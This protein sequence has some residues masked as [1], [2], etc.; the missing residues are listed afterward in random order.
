MLAAGDGSGGGRGEDDDEPTHLNGG[1]GSGN[2]VKGDGSQVD[3]RPAHLQL[4]DH[5]DMGDSSYQINNKDVGHEGDCNGQ[6]DDGDAGHV[7][8]EEGYGFGQGDEGDLGDEADSS[9]FEK[10]PPEV[11]RVIFKVNY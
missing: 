10:L 2:V 7:D 5:C 6:M 1:H 11:F 9:E 8:K 3:G 4:R